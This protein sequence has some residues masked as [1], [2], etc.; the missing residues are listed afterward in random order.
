MRR[1]PAMISSGCL[2]ARVT[3]RNHDRL[4]PDRLLDRVGEF[5]DLGI[6]KI[7]AAMRR[8]GFS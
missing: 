2:T 3:G 8:I 5:S 7:A 4:D 6:G 1:S